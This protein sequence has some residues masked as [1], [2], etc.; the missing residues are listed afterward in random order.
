[1]FDMP[2]RESF[3]VVFTRTVLTLWLWLRRRLKPYSFC[4]TMGEAFQGVK[5]TTD[6]AL[7]TGDTRLSKHRQATQL[8]RQNTTATQ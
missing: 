6:T 2:M 5:A 8:T 1:M 7:K 4:R 3:G